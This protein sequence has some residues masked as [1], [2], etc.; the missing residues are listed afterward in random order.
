M[1]ALL[2]ALSL[3]EE[4][5]LFVWHIN[6]SARTYDPSQSAGPARAA[7]GVFFSTGGQSLP[8][9]AY[10]FVFANARYVEAWILR[11]AQWSQPACAQC[12]ASSPSVDPRPLKVVLSLVATTGRW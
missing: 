6:S 7:P 1:G 3:S 5:P 12:S 8:L 10:L 4:D 2:R 9:L 11:D